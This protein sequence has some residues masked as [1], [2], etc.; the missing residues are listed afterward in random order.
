M[1]VVQGIAGMRGH[2]SNAHLYK[3]NNSNSSSCRSGRLGVHCLPVQDV[4]CVCV[5]SSSALVRSCCSFISTLRCSDHL[6][7]RLGHQAQG[8][9]LVLSE[10]GPELVHRVEAV[11]TL[12][13]VLHC[14]P[15]WLLCIAVALHT[16]TYPHTLCVGCSALSLCCPARLTVVLGSRS[17]VIGGS[18]HKVEQG[19]SV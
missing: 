1:H 4:H 19:Q 18:P 13:L 17:S 2:R 6:Q 14:T 3:H 15:A 16:H 5:A 12:H 9:S 10:T 11:C 8:L 7:P